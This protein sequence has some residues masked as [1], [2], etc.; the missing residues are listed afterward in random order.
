MIDISEI[1]QR[2]NNQAESV[3]KHIFPNAVSEG[4]EMVVGSLF[5]EAGKSLKVCVSGD[6]TGV[7]SEFADGGVSGDLIDLWRESKQISVGEAMSEI[8]A[9]LGIVET[10]FNKS[11]KSKKF[12]KPKAQNGTRLI[13]EDSPTM[14]YLKEERKLDK[15][16]LDKYKISGC[17][18]LGPWPG[19]KKQEPWNGPW[20]VFPF[21][22]P[23]RDLIGIKYLHLQRKGD[24]KQT[25]VSANCKPSLFGWPAIEDSARSVTLTEGELDAASLYQYG[26]PALSV[27]FGGGSGDKQQ[28]VEYEWP[29]LERFELFYLCMDVDSQGEAATKE[30]IARL[31]AHRCK[32][33]TLPR[34]DANLCLQ[35]N[36]KKESIDACFRNAK[37]LDPEELKPA[38][39][40]QDSVEAEFFPDPDIRTGVELPWLKARNK[41]NFRYSEVST[42]TGISGHGK[43][44]VIGQC[45]LHAASQGEK[46][47][48][49]SLEQKPRKTI[50]RMVRQL[51]MERNPSREKI[52]ECFDW[53][54]E[55]FWM[56][57][58]VG[59][60][61][62]DKIFE[63]F[64]HAYHRYG[65]RQFVIDS[66]MRCG[67]N[68]DDYNAQKA[69]VDKLVDFAHEVN[70]HIHLVAHSRKASDEYGTV[71]KLDVKG[72]GAITDLS[73]NTF[74]VWRNKKKEA[75]V[76]DGEANANTL[77]SPDALLVCDKQREGDWEGKVG[78]FFDKNSLRYLDKQE[79]LGIDY[80]AE[81]KKLKE[82][83]EELENEWNR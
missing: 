2:L 47:C 42:W 49:A 4:R 9:Y 57:D 37:M 8:K 22:S 65:I 70:C 3:V 36:I 74:S 81:A 48:I 5:G 76:Q 16:T 63:V 51:A 13:V 68:E 17:D 6:K 38:S 67:I 23:E 50:S 24:K 75:K 7:W 31:G 73:H 54:D 66:L 46:V 79:E 80:L 12:S 21:I 39:E 19:W 56:F 72:T 45:M 55:H 44:M 60:A 69:F 27:P 33:V 41:I 53:M 29:N 10:D 35:D 78:L 28:W 64:R 82:E 83:E 25:L 43:S 18:E 62:T 26:Y 20:I 52:S 61:K 14:K 59:T 40:F 15:S 30:L 11:K 1:K 34:K 77:M 71:G 58:L 32:I